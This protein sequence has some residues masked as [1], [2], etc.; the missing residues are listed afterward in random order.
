MPRPHKH[1]NPIH[2][3]KLYHAFHRPHAL[4]KVYHQFKQ[5]TTKVK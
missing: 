4:N 2:N 5:P 1:I 3:H